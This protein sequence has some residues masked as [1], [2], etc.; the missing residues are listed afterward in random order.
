M[1]HPAFSIKKQKRARFT[2]S[3]NKSTSTATNLRLF[4]IFDHTAAGRWNSSQTKDFQPVKEKEAIS[5]LVMGALTRRRR[6]C[7]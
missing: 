3:M 1:N 5:G 2:K 4:L 7:G 6:L